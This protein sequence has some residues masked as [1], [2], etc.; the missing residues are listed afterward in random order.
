MILSD[1]SVSSDQH[2]GKKNKINPTR[3][4]PL[5]S[6]NPFPIQALHIL[7][8]K[9]VGIPSNHNSPILVS[10][11]TSLFHSLGPPAGRMTPSQMGIHSA[12]CLDFSEARRAA[13]ERRFC[14]AQV[15]SSKVS[16][17]VVDYRKP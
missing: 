5:E 16:D 10:A 17:L 11:L 13:S 1:M 2:D 4:S 14:S 8:L 15:G 9:C 7:P 3:L 6:A 12:W